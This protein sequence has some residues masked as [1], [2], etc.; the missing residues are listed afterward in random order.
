MT[1]GLS[2]SWWSHILEG[3]IKIKNYFRKLGNTPHTWR[4]ISPGSILPSK[5]TAPLYKTKACQMR[6]T[7][8]FTLR[9]VWITK[10]VSLSETQEQISVIGKGFHW[11]EIITSESLQESQKSLSLVLRT[12]ASVYFAY[13]KSLPCLYL[14]CSWLPEVSNFTVAPFALDYRFGSLRWVRLFQKLLI[15]TTL[16][17]IGLYLETSQDNILNSKKK[18]K[19]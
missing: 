19:Q 18:N 13:V 2:M 16:N 15:T 8:P 9:T 12:L 11:Q 14:I 17:K 4:S 10:V 5:S 3:M 1:K 7:D 6:N